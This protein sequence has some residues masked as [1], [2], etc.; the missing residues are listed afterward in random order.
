M[1]GD[2]DDEEFNEADLREEVDKIHI[3]AHTNEHN[4]GDGDAPPTN[5]WSC[6][7]EISPQRSVELDMIPGYGSDGLRGK[8]MASSK[9]CAHTDKA[10]HRL[11]FWPANGRPKVEEIIRVINDNRLQKYTFT[12]EWEGCRFWIFT[13][14]SKL[15]RRGIVQ[16]ASA[17]RVWNAV[18]CYWINPAGFEA[19]PVKEGRFRSSG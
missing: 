11:S 6:F 3:L 5:H 7:L 15:E 13:L 16:S 17:N 8:L 10:I 14:V 19:R 9:Q 1:D 18:S 2:W 12:P 4:E